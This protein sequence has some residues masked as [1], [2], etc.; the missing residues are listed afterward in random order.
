MLVLPTQQPP[1]P[2]FFLAILYHILYCDTA[3]MADCASVKNYA[4]CDG[5]WLRDHHALN[6]G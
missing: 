1:L 6:G 4:E 2:H 3:C 5:S